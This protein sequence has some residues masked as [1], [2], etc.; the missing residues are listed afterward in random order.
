LLLLVAALVDTIMVRVAVQV[1][2]A[3]LLA[4]QVVGHLRNLL[5]LWLPQQHTQ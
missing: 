1:D 5:C 2:T 4:L 3:L